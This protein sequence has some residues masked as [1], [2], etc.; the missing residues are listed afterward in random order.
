[1]RLYFFLSIAAALCSCSRRAER[2]EDTKP[3]PAQ[4]PAAVPDNRR[5]LVV[6]GESLS[7]GFG[8]EAGLSFPDVLQKK[9]DAEGYAW[10][11]VNLGISGDTTE[12]G[13]ARLDSATSLKP[14]IV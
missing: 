5:V 6:F 11:V 1:M 3:A 13:V 12:G 4:V 8:L 9:L 2:T 7:A 14:G 10:H